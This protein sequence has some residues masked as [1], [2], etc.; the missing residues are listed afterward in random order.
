MERSRKFFMYSLLPLFALAFFYIW[1]FLVEESVMMNSHMKGILET[2]NPIFIFDLHRIWDFYENTI[3]FPSMPSFFTLM[4]I[5]CIFLIFLI[6]KFFFKIK[7]YPFIFALFSIFATHSFFF[8]LYVMR[9]HRNTFFSSMALIILIPVLL[10]NF[11]KKLKLFFPLIFFPLGLSIWYL[12]LQ[13]IRSPNTKLY[14]HKQT[15]PFVKEL[16][17]Y[18]SFIKKSEEDIKIMSTFPLTLYLNF[19]HIGFVKDSLSVINDPPIPNISLIDVVPDII[20]VPSG[21]GPKKASQMLRDLAG[22]LS[23]KLVK[24]FKNEIEKK[25]EEFL[26]IEIYAEKGY[27]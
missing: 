11:P 15:V 5:I 9:M 22:R 2:S 13:H 8:S 3:Y 4:S 24:T 20:I 17:L 12:N 10:S 14:T 27:Y 6:M 1:Y 7:E 23:F 19:P 18:V 26:G 16:A 21:F 25:K